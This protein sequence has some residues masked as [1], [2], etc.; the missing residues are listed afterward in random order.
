MFLSVQN[1][2]ARW[3]R[4][5]LEFS[6]NQGLAQ[7]AG[8][9]SGLIYVRVMLVDQY[10]LYA[11]GLSAL[12]FLSVGSDLGLTGA[13]GYYWREAKLQSQDSTIGSLI[14]AIR[15]L[16]LVFLLLASAI[17]AAILVKG[18]GTQ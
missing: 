4:L 3:A 15:K 10:A 1:R 9:I 12:A 6:L 17:S 14:A 16:R 5:F 7:A 11:V 2:V 13:L 8:M 18:A